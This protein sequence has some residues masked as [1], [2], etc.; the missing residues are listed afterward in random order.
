V[1]VKPARATTDVTRVRGHAVA[2]LA[3]AIVVAV[4]AAFAPRGEGSSP[5]PLARPHVLAGVKCAA[6]HGANADAPEPG[7]ACGRCHGPHPSS[8]AAHRA[9]AAKGDLGCTAC[10]PVHG[11]AEGVTFAANGTAVVWRGDAE[12][13]VSVDG[14]AGATVPLVSIDA[15]SRCH[16]AARADDPLRAC[17]AATSTPGAAAYDLCFDEH[18][19]VSSPRAPSGVCAAQHGTAR[20]VAW[21]A[22]REA[23]ASSGAFVAPPT[24]GRAPWLWL[25]SGAAAAAFAFAGVSLARRTRSRRG[26]APAAP[27]AGGSARVRL[28]TI[29]AARCLGCQACVDAC[30]FDVLAV[31]KHVAVVARP[32]ECC[33]VGA[34]EQ[35]CPNGSLLLAEDGETA[36]D[37]PRVDEHLESLDAP[38]VFLAGDLTGVPLIRNAILQGASVADRVAATLTKARPSSPAPE[39]DLVIVGAG[40]AGLSAALRAKELGLACAV[41]EQST[42]AASIRAFPRGKVVHDPPI[43]LPLEG[44]LWLRECTKEE[45]VAQW[46]RIARV[47]RL[48][49]RESHRVVSVDRDGPGFVVGADGPEGPRSVRA[50]RVL[51]AVGRRGTPRPL[52]AEIADAAQG[53]VLGALSDARSLAGRRILV[54]G[55]GDS[56]MEAIAA[57]A[58]QPG[59]TVTVSYRGAGFDR[60]RARNIEEVRRLVE[61]GRVRLLWQS[62]VTRV[63]E[64]WV[65][66]RTPEGVEKL[67]VDVVLALIGGVPGTALLEGAGVR[68]AGRQIEDP[69]RP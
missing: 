47:H 60:G 4:L 50:S 43:E 12:R 27:S 42:L 13:E 34:C 15:C 10:H 66:V 41:L 9:L 25:G 49:V 18:Q 45:L 28:P 30:P 51:L 21:E 39:L 58:R 19:T 20:F 33:G 61:R 69:R 32:D 3:A 2:A 56:A 31:D 62:T 26:P 8:R 37:R 44:S 65:L 48:D 6:C 46:T 64:R 36:G 57:V 68:M 11:V 63:D 5:G 16:D 29:D 59:T 22:A 17:L 14:P 24:R 35:A 40:P 23:A 38:G 7:K 1:A 54:V 53:R 52:A 67:R 55:L